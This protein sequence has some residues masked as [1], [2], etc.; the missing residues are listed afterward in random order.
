MEFNLNRF[1]ELIWNS[2]KKSYKYLIETFDLSFLLKLIQIS[3]KN[4][5]LEVFSS[6][7]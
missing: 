7:N 3:S 2:V 4:K 6:P 5:T 1:S